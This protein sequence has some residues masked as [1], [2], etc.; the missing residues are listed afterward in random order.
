MIDRYALHLLRPV[1]DASAR[2]AAALG[3]TAD[4][5][6]LLGFLAGM[7]AVALIGFDQSWLAIAPLLVNRALDGL[8][9]S[10]A[11]LTRPTDRGAFLDIGLDFVFY[12]AVPLAFAF[13]DP[14]ANALPAAALLAAFIGT[15]TS[16]LAFAVI[17]E[18]RGLKSTAYP[19]KSFYYLGGLTEGAETIL[20][21]ILMCLWPQWFAT[22]AYVY[23][24]MCAVTM[25]T[26]L[27][28]GWRIFAEDAR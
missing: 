15:G 18:K 23:G 6:T 20:C 12:A 17:A 7:V 21:F 16:F 3:L 14:G 2:R 26:R 25:V 8:D 9:G 11:R 10:L 13:C 5:A 4:A 24:A 1:I 27:V 19:A 28:A 22:I